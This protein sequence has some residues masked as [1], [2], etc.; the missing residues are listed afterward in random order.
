MT[1]RNLVALAVS[2]LLASPSVGFAAGGSAL[3]GGYTDTGTTSSDRVGESVMDIPDMA[4]G[5]P[6]PLDVTKDLQ[7][8]GPQTAPLKAPRKTPSSPS[9]PPQ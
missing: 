8:T 4:I 6:P 7:S 3:G 2:I 5:G 9:L 1:N